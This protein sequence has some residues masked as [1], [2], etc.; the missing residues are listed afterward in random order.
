MR[1]VER[2]PSAHPC[3][4]D[5]SPALAS[6]TTDSWPGR[7]LSVRLTMSG[8]A[9]DV[10]GGYPLQSRQCVASPVMLR[11]ADAGA[12]YLLRPGGA[13]PAGFVSRAD[14][15]GVAGAGASLGAGDDAENNG[16]KPLNAQG[17]PRATHAQGTSGSAAG[18]CAWPRAPLL[19]KRRMGSGR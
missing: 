17:V 1:T 8:E 9:A 5:R 2:A 10:P 15:V 6:T 18:W 4:R 11:S 14:V 7:A 12:P 3:A 13:C 16:S 19:V